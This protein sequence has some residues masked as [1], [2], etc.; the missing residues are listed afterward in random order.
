MPIRP[1][2]EHLLLLYSL[3][4]VWG[5]AGGWKG[6]IHQVELPSLAPNTE[7]FYRVGDADAGFT[8]VFSFTTKPLANDSGVYVIGMF[9]DMGTVCILCFIAFTWTES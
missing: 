4:C 8:D 9:G 7:Y 1:V 6:V 2:S 3:M 5:A